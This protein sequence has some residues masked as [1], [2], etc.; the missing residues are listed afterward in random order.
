MHARLSKRHAGSCVHALR[1]VTLCR[2]AAAMTAMPCCMTLTCASAKA[3]CHAL[4]RGGRQR[5]CSSDDRQACW[6][7]ASSCHTILS[8]AVRRVLKNS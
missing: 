7:A 6:W 3:G 1:V 5:R 2:V 4:C 8:R